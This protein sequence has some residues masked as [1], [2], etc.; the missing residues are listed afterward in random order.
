V[1]HPAGPDEVRAWSPA[2]PGVSEVFHARFTQHAYPAHA[3]V[4]WTVLIVDDGMVRYDL[5]RHPHGSDTS[6]VTILPPHVVHDGRPATSRGFRKR[7]LYLDGD[8]LGEGLIGPA[9]D[10][11]IILDPGL[12]DR[13]ST[14]HRVLARVDA[15][16]ATPAEAAL[17][18]ESRLAFVIERLRRHLNDPSDDLRWVRGATVAEQLRAMLDADVAASLTLAEAGRALGAS[19]AHLVRSFT[20][21]YGVAPHAYLVGRRID[22]ARRRLL[23]G[24]PPAEVAVGVG[25]YDQAH[26]TRHFKRHVGTTPGR[27]ATRPART[28]GA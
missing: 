2:V 14:V 13:I 24:E 1:A 26:L 5:D 20:R 8:V 18:A 15:A 12:R 22:L 7:V 4:T 27:Y 28:S 16:P 9:V 3:H 21:T 6:M 25:F 10:R 17:E 23:D 19:P 11:P